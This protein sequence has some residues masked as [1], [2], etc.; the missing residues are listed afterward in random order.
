MYPVFSQ[1]CYAQATPAYRMEREDLTCIKTGVN[2]LKS[3]LEGDDRLIKSVTAN[4]QLS[5]DDARLTLNRI[6]SQFPFRVRGKREKSTVMC[7]KMLLFF[8]SSDIHLVQGM[9]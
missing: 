5:S 8:S 9:Q 2:V 6:G 3:V 7:Q 4:P 1:R